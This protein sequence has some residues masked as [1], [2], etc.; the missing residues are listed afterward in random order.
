MPESTLLVNVEPAETRVAL[1][2]DGALAELHVERDADR[3]IVGNIYLGT[4]S[5]VMR[6]M[7]A[8]F[9]DIGLER[10]AFLQVGDSVRPG[11]MEARAAP[12]APDEEQHG[13]LRISKQTPIGQVL[14]AGQDVLVQV[15]RAPS[16]TKG[17]RVTSHVSLPGRVLVYLPTLDQIGVSH[18]ITDDVERQRL[19]EVIESLRTGGGYIVRTVAAGKPREVLAREIEHLA[20]MWSDILDRRSG[21]TPPAAVHS[22]LDLALRATRDLVNDDV[23]LV[24]DDGDTFVR[25]ESFV[26]KF[27]P[28]AAGRISLYEGHEPLFDAHGI[29]GLV[30]RALARVI[31]LPSGGTLIID[32]AEALT[33]IDV[34]TGRFAG[35]RDLEDTITRTN[36]EAVA[37]LASQ[38]RLRNIGG[39]I[40]VD[41]IDMERAENRDKVNRA[42][43]EAVQR[44]RAHTTVNQ[45]SDLGLVEM[46]RHGTNQGL[47]L[48]LC[49][50][51]QYCD[52]TG[53]LRSRATVCCDLLREIRRKAVLVRA[54]R[55]VVEC[56]PEVAALLGR[57]YHH[58]LAQLERRLATE[59]EV[60]DRPDFHLERFD[61]TGGGKHGQETA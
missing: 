32:H 34:N 40:V 33:A 30:Q 58:P 60:R 16:G 61:I 51:C 35:G 37:E 52:G 48:Q 17:P 29:E 2:E 22:D 5:R 54:P 57:E 46:T 55:L 50:P 23:R 18:R 53:R 39:L 11:D 9:I 14:Q 4:V 3:S 45:I 19:R 7:Q 8:A 56:H 25:I 12:G 24:V 28:E 27:L 13:S 21:L 47:A 44:D 41:F 10:H 1:V 43:Q 49:E 6:G 59:I 26:R 31:P 15:T 36:L 42:L 20:L 38:I